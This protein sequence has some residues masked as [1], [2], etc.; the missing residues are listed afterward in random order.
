MLV[1]R[2]VVI[3][4]RGLNEVSLSEMYFLIRGKRW[5]NIYSFFFSG[6]GV[7]VN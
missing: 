1:F 7:E 5:E 2:L 3:L 6:V 4:E